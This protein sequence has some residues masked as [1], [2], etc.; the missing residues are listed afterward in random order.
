MPFLCIS[1]CFLHT[2]MFFLSSFVLYI[3]VT[4]LRVCG[5]VGGLMLV[6]WRYLALCVAS[7]PSR[8]SIPSHTQPHN[9]ITLWVWLGDGIVVARAWR[10]VVLP[11]GHHMIWCGITCGTSCRR[12]FRAAARWACSVLAHV[13][14]LPQCDQCDCGIVAI[15]PDV[16]PGHEWVDGSYHM[17]HYT[18]FSWAFQC[19]FHHVLTVDHFRLHLTCWSAPYVGYYWFFSGGV[20]YSLSCD[21]F[22]SN[23]RPMCWNLDWLAN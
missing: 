1:R 22:S 3:V 14:S 16:S 21:W 6:T 19:V 10:P 11:A 8:D 13:V 15:D 5:V 9:P 12:P 20:E 7:L 17:I 4:V 23:Y 18:H 2:H